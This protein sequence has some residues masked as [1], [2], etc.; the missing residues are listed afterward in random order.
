MNV[1]LN[2]RRF[3]SK[4]LVRVVWYVYIIFFPPNYIHSF[5]QTRSKSKSPYLNQARVSVSFSLMR[6]L[7]LNAMMNGL[8]SQDYH[9]LLAELVTRRGN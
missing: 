8:F 2:R 7:R 1:L 6:F 9:K 4:G 3:N 5:I